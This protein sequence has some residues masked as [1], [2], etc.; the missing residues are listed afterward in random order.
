MDR[1]A[2]VGVPTLVAPEPVDVPSDPDMDELARIACARY[3]QP[4]D[5]A[6][7]LYP[8]TENWTYRVEGE[9]G[10]PRVLR[11]YRPGG[12]SPAEILSELAWMEAIRAEAGSLVP[13][14]IP[15]TM[16]SQVLELTRGAPLNPCHCV[17]FSCAPGREPAEDELAAWFPRLGAI[18]AR[19]HRHARSWVRPSWFR[20]PRWD[21]S[22]TLGDR[23]HWGPWQSSVS[24]AVELRQLERL[25]RVVT[26]RLR[27]F[28]DGDGRFGLVHADLRLANLLV[29]G[30]RITVIDFEDCGLSWYLYDLACALTFN[31]GRSDVRELIALWVDGY[32]AVEPL[33]AEDEAEIDTFLMLRRLMLTAYAGLRHDTELAAQMRSGGYN[34]ETCALA[35]AYLS[36]CG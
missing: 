22:T 9:A 26:E 16:G 32:R 8:L 25:A 4:A 20:R 34:A 7:H 12:R 2:G 6:L 23:P 21:L 27:G 13:A 24:D 1:G 33:A 36:R 29:D 14:V 31:E 18:T 19:L 10:V 17:M 11:I 28:G 35:E 15:T 30:D 3:G 5:S